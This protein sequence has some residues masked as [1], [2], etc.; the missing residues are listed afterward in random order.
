MQ[1]PL[2][3]AWPV[4]AGLKMDMPPDGAI[5]VSDRGVDDCS[6][7]GAVTAAGRSSGWRLAAEPRCVALTMAYPSVTETHTTAIQG[8][9]QRALVSVMRANP[10]ERVMARPLQS[11]RRA[12]QW[13]WWR[14]CGLA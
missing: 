13:Q 1:H 8:S 7:S 12:G 9:S 4:D 3:D 5:T 14:T 2:G 10:L 6:S 11:G